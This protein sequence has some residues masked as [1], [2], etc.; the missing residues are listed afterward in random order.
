MK[1]LVFVFYT[2]LN[3]LYVQVWYV[4]D[5]YQLIMMLDMQVDG[6]CLNMFS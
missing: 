6:L 1:S 3:I 2:K 4:L 5:S